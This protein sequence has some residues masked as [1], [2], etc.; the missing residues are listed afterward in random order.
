MHEMVKHGRNFTMALR[1]RGAEALLRA[2][3]AFEPDIYWDV[4][5]F[6]GRDMDKRTAIA[7]LAHL[8]I[9]DPEAVKTGLWDADDDRDD[10]RTVAIWALAAHFFKG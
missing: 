4:V 7:V 8:R 3:W 6:L 1:K 2:A 5:Q 10:P 9:V